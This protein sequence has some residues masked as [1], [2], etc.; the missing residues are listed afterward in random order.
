MSHS[1]GSNVSTRSASGVQLLLIETGTDK[2]FCLLL[3]IHIFKSKS[4]WD[5]GSGQVDEGARL[6]VGRLSAFA[7][8]E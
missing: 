2:H 6:L 3:C 5:S 7:A 4:V 1:E 8:R